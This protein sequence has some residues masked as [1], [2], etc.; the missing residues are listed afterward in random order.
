MRK[1]ISSFTDLPISSI[2]KLSTVYITVKVKPFGI[3]QDLPYV[4]LSHAGSS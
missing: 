4:S 3:Q 2:A 1:N